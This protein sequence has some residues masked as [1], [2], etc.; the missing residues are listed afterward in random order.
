[1]KTKILILLLLFFANNTLFA[2][3]Y[4]TLKVLNLEAETARIAVNQ[5]FKDLKLPHMHIWKNQTSAKSSFYLYTSLMIK[6]RLVFNINVEPNLLT[7]SITNRQYQSSSHWVDNP[8]PMSKKQAAKILDP[9]KERIIELT[10]SK[11]ITQNII[12]SKKAGIFEDFAIIKTDDP[13]MDL[14]ALHINNNI[15]GFDLFDD[16]KTVKTLLYKENKDSEAIILEFDENGL[17]KY[18]AIE[19]FNIKINSN[20]S[21]E[22]DLLIKDNDSK[23]ISKEKNFIAPPTLNNPNNILFEKNISHG[24]FNNNE[25]LIS[26]SSIPDALGFAS[27]AFSGILAGLQGPKQLVLETIIETAKSMGITLADPNNK[28]LLNELSTAIGLIGLEA[29]VTSA[30]TSVMA[31]APSLAPIVPQLIFAG[32]VVT[33]LKISY[34]AAMRIKERHWPT[35]ISDTNNI[36]INNKITKN[37]LPTEKASV[38]TIKATGLDDKAAIIKLAHEA[39]SKIKSNTNKI[40]ALGKLVNETN[41]EKI[42]TEIKNLEDTSKQLRAEY[43]EKIKSIAEKETITFTTKKTDPANYYSIGAI[44]VVSAHWTNRWLD[45]LVEVPFK[46]FKIQ[47]KLNNELYYETLGDLRFNY[48]DNNGDIIHKN[49][50]IFTKFAMVFDDFEVIETIDFYE[51]LPKLIKIEN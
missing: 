50:V 11:I 20:A 41:Y 23:L 7:V 42:G 16:L 48:L 10:K 43:G 33:G 4:T 38:Y 36:S 15:I 47:K 31:F 18:L 6:N 12:S 45:I 40:E 46:T 39:M 19:N 26:N 51:S 44:K 13:E 21:G 14:L 3:D 17:P 25:I 49:T 8:L 28:F 9:I 5:T 27:T 35:P 37:N 2:Q 22:L 29:T 32:I 30:T 34:D 24:P 1:M